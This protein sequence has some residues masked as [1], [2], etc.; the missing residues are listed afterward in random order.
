MHFGRERQQIQE[1]D[2]LE[3][4]LGS[5]VSRLV[6]D[7]EVGTGDVLVSATNAV[8]DLLVLGLFDGR[9]VGLH[10]RRS[11]K[12]LALGLEITHLVTTTHLLLRIVDGY[13]T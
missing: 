5:I 6:S 4:T 8:T 10:E 1:S 13:A 9:F 3:S 7:G 12:P 11:I 2:V